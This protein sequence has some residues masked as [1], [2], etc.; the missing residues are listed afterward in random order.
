MRIKSDAL[1]LPL[2]RWVR[3]LYFR[4]SCGGLGSGISVQ[5]DL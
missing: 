5:D 2:M 3:C 1:R 4:V